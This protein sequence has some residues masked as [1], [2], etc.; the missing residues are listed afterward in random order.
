[1]TARAFDWPQYLVDPVARTAVR[2]TSWNE[3]QAPAWS[4]DGSRFI[5]PSTGDIRLADGTTVGRL[6]S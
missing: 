3:W 5:S 4:P 1:M 6:V 2:M